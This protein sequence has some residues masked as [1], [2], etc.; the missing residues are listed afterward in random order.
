MQKLKRGL[1]SCPLHMGGD[2]CIP[3]HF[4]FPLF[5]KL[6]SLDSLN[7]AFQDVP[8][9]S[10]DSSELEPEVALLGLVCGMG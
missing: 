6:C 2:F 7:L 1:E 9:F 3:W 10:R 8:I 5:L 4:A